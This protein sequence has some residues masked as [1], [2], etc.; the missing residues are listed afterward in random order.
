[1]LHACSPSMFST[2]FVENNEGH[3]E[4]HDTTLDQ[5]CSLLFDT[6]E[7]LIPCPNSL[8]HCALER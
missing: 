5:W 3:K 1:M 7:Q 2:A 8:F 6:G 4:E